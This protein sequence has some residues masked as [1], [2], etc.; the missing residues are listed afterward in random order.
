MLSACNYH[1][2]RIV[3]CGPPRLPWDQARDA[4]TGLLGEGAPSQGRIEWTLAPSPGHPTVRV[5]LFES[6]RPYA[7]IIDSARVGLASVECFAFTLPS[8][9]QELVQQL[10]ALLV[11]RAA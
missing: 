8:R 11:A 3:T 5:T 6:D 2:P 7:Y 10:R 1:D 9:L 4:I